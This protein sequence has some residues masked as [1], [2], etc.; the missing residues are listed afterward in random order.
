MYIET[1]IVSHATA[2]PS[3]LP[4]VAVLQQQARSWWDHERAKYRL[5]TSHFVITEAASGD[6]EAARLR[7]EMLAGIPLLLPSEQVEVIASE[8]LRRALMPPKAKFDALHVAMAA[9]GGVDYLLTQN[10]KHI[11]NAHVLPRV[12][13]L[14]AELGL[15][16]LLVCTPAEFLGGLEYVDES[17]S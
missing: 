15:P 4:A 10:C 13:D 14:L 16:R 2:R 1:S 5:V 12:Y 11:A 17:D 6:A 8:I 7:L 3:N 9:C